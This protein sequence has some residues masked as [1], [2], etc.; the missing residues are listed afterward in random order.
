[1]IS[2][3]K[4]T[5]YRM[6]HFRL[7]YAYLPTVENPRFSVINPADKSIFCYL[8]SPLII[9][10]FLIYRTL[11]LLII[12]ISLELSSCTTLCINTESSLTGRQL[13]WSTAQVLLYILVAILFVWLVNLIVRLPC[14][15]IANFPRYFPNVSC[16]FSIALC[17]L[18]MTHHPTKLPYQ[19]PVQTLRT[20]AALPQV[21]ICHL[22]VALPQRL[23]VVCIWAT[24]ILYLLLGW[25]RARRAV[26]SGCV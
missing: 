9:S 21:L 10:R 1:M 26:W 5:T 6:Y 23:L 19:R 18:P 4:L 24:C 3:A 12:A 17:R 2:I 20:A 16:W 8:Y 13:A 25:L 7:F 22:L 11:Y 15:Q 14:F